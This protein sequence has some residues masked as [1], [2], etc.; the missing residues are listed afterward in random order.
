MK[1][2]SGFER[3]EDANIQIGDVGGVACHTNESSSSS[4]GH[5]RE[6]DRIDAETV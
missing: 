6:Y 2:L 4:S 3:L 1:S 5:N